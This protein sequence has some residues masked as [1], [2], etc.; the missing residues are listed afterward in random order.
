M[1]KAMLF[2]ICLA[3]ALAMTACHTETDPWPV[4]KDGATAAPQA[5]AAPAPADAP[6][7]A[8]GGQQ[9]VEE[10]QQPGGE[11]DPGING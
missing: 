8:P 6:A 5:T 10:T 4:T 7:D 3:A 9:V 11:E 2:V 1:R